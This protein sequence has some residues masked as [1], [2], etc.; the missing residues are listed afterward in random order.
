MLS[1]TLVPL[2][3]R[4]REEDDPESTSVL[5]SV[6]FVAATLLSLL[7]LAATFAVDHYLHGRFTAEGGDT[8]STLVK[9]QIVTDLLYLMLPQILF[10][11]IASLS[12]AYLNASRRYRTAAFAPVLT[13]LVTIVAFAIVGVQLQGEDVVLDAGQRD[14]SA[15]LWLGLGTTA[16]IAA[17]VIPMMWAVRNS[18]NKLQFLPRFGH[19]VVKRVVRLSGWTFGYV[20]A[21]QLALL[22]VVLL[23]SDNKRYNDAFIFFQLPHGL[24]AVSI[25]TTMTPELASAAA[26]RDFQGLADRFARGL[27]LLASLIVPAAVGY[28]LLAT[29]ITSFLRHGNLTAEDAR[30]TGRA[31]AAFAVGLPAFSTYLFACRGF[32]ALS[33]TRTP[34]FLNVVENGINVLGIVGLVIVGSA[35]STTFA[36]AYS[37]AYVLAA[38]LAVW[39]FDRRLRELDPD[40]V[41]PDLSPLRAMAVAA[42]GMGVVVW[43]IRQALPDDAGAGAVASVALGVVLGGLTYLGLGIVLRV[44]EITAVWAGA[45]RRFL[46]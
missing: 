35:S 38:I 44:P 39:R 12:T 18:N 30:L 45:R 23:L 34:F 37:V 2:F 46:R 28:V 9:L 36:L 11:A 33:D 16:G 15:V 42:L 32:Y 43:L 3:V 7:A 4:S 40:V 27:R 20:I 19:P 24:I 31:V 29:P 8:A 13:N 6:G 21:N 5:I 41:R 25:M 26:R 14:L 17:M 22:A 10:Y 1:A